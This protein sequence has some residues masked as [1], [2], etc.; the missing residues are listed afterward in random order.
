MTVKDTVMQNV[1][2]TINMK[3]AR[4]L[5]TPDCNRD[6]KLCCNKSLGENAITEVT[7][8]EL[9]GYDEIN[10]TGGEPMLYPDELKALIHRIKQ[11]NKKV[12]M[13]TAHPFPIKDF[14]IILQMLDGCT[15]TLHTHEDCKNFRV[16]ELNKL[17]YPHK[18]LRLKV[19]PK[20]KIESE[21]W[22]V[23]P[24]KWI[25]DCPLPDGEILVALKQTNEIS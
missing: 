22:D 24:T 12:F 10:I 5:F 16:F 7:F 1:E 19:F 23:R 9:M 6:C 20:V 13:Y 14:K 18:S 4:L 3:R 21:V 8:E 15:L 25:V 2:A 17:E 11:R